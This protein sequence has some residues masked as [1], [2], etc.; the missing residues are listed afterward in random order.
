MGAAIHGVTWGERFRSL[1]DTIGII[2][3]IGVILG[4]IYTGWMTPTEVGG[5]GAFIIFLLALAKREMTS[6]DLVDSLME[7]SKLTVMIFTIIWSVLIYVRFL[8]FT[9]LPGEFAD[10]IA[11]L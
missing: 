4:G 5:V 10:W 7:T 3:V 11:S 6:K 9:G 2:G 1:K 8:G